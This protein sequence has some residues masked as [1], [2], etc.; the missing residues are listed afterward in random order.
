MPF[1]QATPDSFGDTLYW[2]GTS[3]LR[4]FYIEIDY[5]DNEISFYVS[6]NAPAGVQVKVLDNND[7]KEFNEE[8][9][10]IL[11]SSIGGVLVLGG[12][13]FYCW[14][15]NRRSQHEDVVYREAQQALI[16]HKQSTN[17]IQ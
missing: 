8:L 5:S 11:C 10:I 15:R 12:I 16:R 17:L 13:G 7:D 6:A 1:V 9:V 2:I 14:K 4:N 3:L